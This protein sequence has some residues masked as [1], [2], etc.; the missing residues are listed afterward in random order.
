MRTYFLGLATIV[1]VCVGCQ[2]GAQHLGQSPDECPPGYAGGGMPRSDAFVNGHRPRRLYTAPPAH[3]LVRP[4]PMVDGPGPGVLNSIAMPPS[5]TFQTTSTQVRFVAPEAMAIGW[6]IGAGYAENQI[7]APGVYNFPQGATYR[8]KLTNIPGRDGVILYPTMQVYPAHPQT[9]AYLSHNPVPVQFTDEDLDQVESN[10]FVTKVIYL[11]SPKHQELAIAGVETLVST[12]LDPGVDPIA[13][14]DRRGTIMA[15]IRIGN[16]DEE[17][18]LQAG[19]AGRDGI[20][21]ASHIEPVDGEAGQFMAP[22]P[23]GTVPGQGHAIPPAMVMGAP[24]GPGMPATGG[25]PT[26]G[27]PITGTPI[28]LPG[29]PHLPYGAPAGLRSHTVRNRTRQDIPEPV[30]DMLIDVKHKPGIRYPRPVNHVK[31]TESHPVVD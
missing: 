15:V 30:S 7:Y 10:N 14:A 31:Y 5:R 18:P 1:A 17:T 20:Q 11:P 23:I 28:G 9:D 8:L 26:W 19:I 16:K 27:M 4:G 2:T 13:E 24:G 29:P 6:Q 21:Q 25:G 22:V 3:M 12:R